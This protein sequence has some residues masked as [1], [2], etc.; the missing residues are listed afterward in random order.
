MTKL[1]GGMLLGLFGLVGL[2]LILPIVANFLN[3]TAQAAVNE[4]CQD[5]LKVVIGAL[6]GSVSTFFGGKTND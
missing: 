2:L 5:A 6:V 1:Q 3:P 4:M